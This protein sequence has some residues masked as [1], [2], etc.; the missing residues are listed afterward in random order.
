M[1]NYDFAGK[2]AEFGKKSTAFVVATVIRTEGSSLA[3]PGFKVVIQNNSVQYGT[4]GGACPETVILDEAEKVLK[5]GQPK[6][7]KIHLEDAGMGLNAMV[8]KRDENEI[9]VETFCGGTIEVYLEPYFPSQRL[10]IIGQGGKDD[11]EEAL[12]S[13]GR[14]L[15]F[16]VVVVD[17]APALEN[18]PDIL[19]DEL[20]FDLS[21]FNV[22]TG[23]FVVILTKGERDIS[24][25][26]ALSG[27]EP[28]YIGLLA[29][30]KRIKHDFEVLTKDGISREFLDSIHAPIGIDIGAVSPFEIALSIASQIVS[31]RHNLQSEKVTAS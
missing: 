30:R 24:T 5:S 14:L 10:I 27:K 12:V 26:K 31:I 19:H 16:K 23:D 28:S 8:S 4:L 15:N 18:K 3:K 11:I 22:G 17:H 13:I 20:D 7:V 2:L 29:S 1:E 9:F 25:L 21:N 6:V